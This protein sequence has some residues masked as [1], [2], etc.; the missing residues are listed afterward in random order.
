MNGRGGVVHQRRPINHCAVAAQQPKF[1][2][3]LAGD[4]A[5]GW[6]AITAR[7]QEVR[8]DGKQTKH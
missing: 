6:A 7:K 1:E 5:G 4:N 2:I 8:L 3:E